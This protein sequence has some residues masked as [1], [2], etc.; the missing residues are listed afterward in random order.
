MQN[1]GF[2]YILKC[3]NGRFYTGSTDNVERRVQEHQQGKVTATK[4]LLPIELV[5]SQKFG[6]LKQARQVEYNLKRKKSASIIKRIIN[7]GYIG[8][9]GP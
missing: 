2:V 7:E 8:F 5:F 1:I 3:T 6:T 4:N 9:A